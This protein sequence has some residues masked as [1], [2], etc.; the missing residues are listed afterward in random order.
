MKIFRVAA[1]L[2]A[3]LSSGCTPPPAGESSPVSEQPAPDT[4]VVLLAPN[5]KVPP[6]NDMAR[7]FDL[8]I[9]ASE[10]DSIRKLYFEMFVEPVLDN[11]KYSV[12]ATW[13]E[14]KRLTER[15]SADAVKRTGLTSEG[16]R[17]LI[18]WFAERDH[19]TVGSSKDDVLRVQGTPDEISDSMRG[20]I[21]GGEPPPGGVRGGS[22][23]RY[24]SSCVFF[25]KDRVTRWNVWPSSPLKVKI[26]PSSN[27]ESNLRFSVGSSKD[28]VLFAQGPPNAFS[29]RSWRYGDS[30]VFFEDG[31]VTRW[32]QSPQHPLRVQQP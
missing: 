12:S 7:M 14:F 20:G 24:G 27:S 8:A 4:L 15:P 1:L 31:R 28:E 2:I 26:L 23:W 29:E 32:Q 9:P 30:V 6:F 25:A 11:R 22:A 13:E 10:Y 21:C 3:V 18:N 19:F 17:W 5:Q 16:A